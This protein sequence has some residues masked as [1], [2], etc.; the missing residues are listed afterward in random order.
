MLRDLSR[1]AK[2]YASDSLSDGPFIFAVP[3]V[4][5]LDAVAAGRVVAAVSPP[6]TSAS[7]SIGS[8]NG[9]N[10]GASGDIVL[11]GGAAAGQDSSDPSLKV[12]LDA[13]SFHDDLNSLWTVKARYYLLH[14]RCSSI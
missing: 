6:S 8:N 14:P 11:E 3:P 13:A 9:G 5:Y 1:G 2:G 10:K 4:L 7:S 12:L